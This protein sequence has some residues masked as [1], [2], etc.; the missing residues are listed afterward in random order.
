MLLGESIGRSRKRVQ[1]Q[2]WY[3]RPQ[4]S[5]RLVQLPVTGRLTPGP[6]AL[7]LLSGQGDTR[8]VSSSRR[9]L[10]GVAKSR[11]LAFHAVGLEPKRARHIQYSSLAAPDTNLLKRFAGEFNYFVD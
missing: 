7:V 4:S 9:C 3:G 2:D 6:S 5:D 10:V 8:K 1:H 11:H